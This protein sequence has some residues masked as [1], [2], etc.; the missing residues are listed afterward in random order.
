MIETLAFVTIVVTQG[1]PE[2]PLG[3]RF[4]SREPVECAV[5]MDWAIQMIED[6]GGKADGHCEY[7]HAPAT[8]V[9]PTKRR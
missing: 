4:Y 6:Q 1:T 3:T 5:A 9:R 2:I 8:S 7:T